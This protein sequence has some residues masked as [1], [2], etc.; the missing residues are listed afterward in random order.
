V[1]RIRSL[2]TPVVF[3]AVMAAAMSAEPEQRKTGTLIEIKSTPPSGSEVDWTVLEPD[4]LEFRIYDGGQ[5]FVTTALSKTGMV[6]ILEIVFT[7]GPDG[8]LLKVKKLNEFMVG[9]PPIPKPIVL[10]TATLTTDVSSMLTSDLKP[11]NLTWETSPPEVKV[12]LNTGDG[13]K[14]V[15]NNGSTVVLPQRTTLY[16]LSATDSAGRTAYS[17]T[18]ITVSDK[19]P[20]DVIP[21]GPILK[22][23][24][25]VLIVYDADTKQRLPA[26]QRNMLMSITF[27]DYL[28]SVCVKGSTGQADAR[29]YG[30]DVAGLIGPDQPELREMAKLERKSLPWIVVSPGKGTVGFS[31]L[32]PLDEAATK[33][34][35]ER[36]R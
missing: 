30:S 5:T 28:D 27:R 1:K 4:D 35:I 15:D 16:T 17:Q 13:P 20:P 14:D 34:L 9:P 8:K 36:Y 2:M 3:L 7:P 32:L 12:Q 25:R 24:V 11:A 22:Q 21:P 6:R 33:A 23:G 18:I 31:G 10:P 26:S 19:P 29:M